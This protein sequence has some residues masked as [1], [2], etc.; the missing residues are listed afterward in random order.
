MASDGAII[1]PLP[2]EQD[3]SAPACDLVDIGRLV[4]AF[5]IDGVLVVVVMLVVIDDDV[6]LLFGT[7]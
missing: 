5:T 2:L 4:I 7:D 1:P 3:V 6:V